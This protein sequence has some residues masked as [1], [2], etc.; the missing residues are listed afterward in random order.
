MGLLVRTIFALALTLCCVQ[1]GSSSGYAAERRSK[2]IECFHT[3]ISKSLQSQPALSKL[4]HYIESRKLQFGD[5]ELEVTP[6]DGAKLKLGFIWR[7][8]KRFIALCLRAVNEG[9]LSEIDAGPIVGPKAFI[10][11][12]HMM[13]KPPK[14][15][16]NVVIKGTFSQDVLEMARAEQSM[17]TATRRESADPREWTEQEIRDFNIAARNF[18]LSRCHAYECVFEIR[19]KEGLATILLTAGGKPI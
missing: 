6:T 10:M 4:I 7:D 9:S 8:E 17:G 1:Q 12:N 16:A 19:I 2:V 11:L 14:A 5:H 15:P 18:G 13:S 3:Q